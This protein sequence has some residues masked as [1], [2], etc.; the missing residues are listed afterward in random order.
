MYR[1]FTAI[2]LF[3]TPFVALSHP[4]S[5]LHPHDANTI[6]WEKDGVKDGNSAHNHFAN[7]NFGAAGW[8]KEPY[9]A[10]SCWDGNILRTAHDN[11]VFPQLFVGGHC[12]TEFEVIPDPV[13][14]KYASNFPANMRTVVNTAFDKFN[15]LSTNFSTVIPHGKNGYRNSLGSGTDQQHTR[16]CL[17]LSNQ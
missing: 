5:K 16:R 6:E 4:V 10:K 1:L 3:S 8:F 2:V 9:S 13:T 15:D 11:S 14:Y 12:Y 17:C 7:R